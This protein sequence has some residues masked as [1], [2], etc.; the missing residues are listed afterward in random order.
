MQA[1]YYFISDVHLRLY[2]SELEQAKRRHL[3]D[4]LREVEKESAELYIV[5]DLFDFWFEYKYVI[6]RHFFKIIRALQRTA[7]QGCRIHLVVGNHDYWVGDFFQNE[8]GVQIHRNPVDLQM[9]AQKWLVTHGDGILKRD[10][11]YRILKK[12]LRH[13]MSIFLFRLLHPDLAFAIAAKISQRS[14]HATLRQPAFIE[15]E[16]QE[17]I[18]FGQQKFSQGYDCVITGHFH[19]PTDY[20][21]GEHIFLNLGD[22]MRHYSFAYYNGNSLK[23]CYWNTSSSGKKRKS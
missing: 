21:E 9:G 20:R 22:W 18:Q 7:E 23:L 5:G 14:R 11:G 16:R 1:K 13:P 19:L 15:S 8:I 12:V 6:P 10:T 2:D 17:I 3:L 4:F